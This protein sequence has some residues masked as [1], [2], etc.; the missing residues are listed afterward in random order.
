MKN[1]IID[2]GIGSSEAE[3]LV[4]VSK[5]I[6]KDYKKLLKGYPIQYLIGYSNFYGY[7]F[8]LNKRT[9]IPR[10]ETELLVEKTIQYINKYIP[11]VKSIIDLGTGSGCIA[12]SLSKELPN[13]LVHGVDISLS[14]LRLAK[15]NNT[16][17]NSAVKFYKYNILKEL[18]CNYDVIISNPP[19][20]SKNEEV[21]ISVKKY[22]PRK[23]LYAKK[24]GTQF[25]EQII[26][27]SVNHLNKPGIIAFEI[28]Y[29]QSIEIKKLA[30]LYYPNSRILIEKDLSGKDRYL[31]IISE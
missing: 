23:A 6:K 3:E 12:I 8:L 20:V 9:L 30:E 15:K 19:Y 1:K 16:I 18:E 28:G 29:K 7:K 5:N 22:E 25:Y 27:N 13:S 2:L 24:D 21:D 26:K 14:A 4:K 10:F 17:N 11:N 31:F